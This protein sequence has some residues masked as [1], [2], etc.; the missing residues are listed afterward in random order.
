MPKYI[1]TGGETGEANVEVNG[2]T[3]APGDSIELK[4]NDWLIKAGYVKAVK[5]KKGDK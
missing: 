2:K 1:V 4:P 3:Y 5:P